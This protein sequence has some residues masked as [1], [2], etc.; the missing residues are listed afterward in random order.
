MKYTGITRPVDE[1]GRIV[2]PKEI[3]STMNISSKDLLEIHLD[4]DNIVLK[5]SENRCVL[6]GSDNELITYN[7][8]CVCNS[9]VDGLKN[10]LG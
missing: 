7:G 9:C 5:K 10:L 2:I 6:C 8:K 4:G 1:L 3:R